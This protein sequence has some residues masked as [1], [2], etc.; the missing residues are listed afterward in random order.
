[1]CLRRFPPTV[2]RPAGQVMKKV[3]KSEYLTVEEKVVADLWVGQSVTEK[4]LIS[5]GDG[6]VVTSL[7][8]GPSTTL[9][10]LSFGGG[11]GL[12]I[13]SALT[14]TACPTLIHS[15]QVTHKNCL[16]KTVLLGPMSSC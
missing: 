5:P 4:N 1:M 8:Y 11:R 15:S 10:D 9:S 6:A 7:V 3:Q 12:K 14:P 2:Q 13:D 16:A